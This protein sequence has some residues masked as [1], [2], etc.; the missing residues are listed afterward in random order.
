MLALNIDAKTYGEHNLATVA[1]E[2]QSTPGDN[3]GS[4]EH[5]K[6]QAAVAPKA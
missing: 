2:L 3:P 5:S 4:T 6:L 1:V